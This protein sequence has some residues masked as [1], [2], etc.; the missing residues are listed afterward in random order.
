MNRPIAKGWCPGAYRPMM[1]G[2]GLVVR[3][4][5]VMV[6]LDR[7]QILGLC[8]LAERFGSGLIDLTSR[9]NL[10]IRGVEKTDHEAL[11]QELAGLGLLQD[12]PELEG[13]RN[14]LM[15]PLWLQGDASQQIVA[16]L[17][18]R[19]A[20]LP[21]LPVKMGFAVDTGPAPMLQEN[22]ADFRFERDAT[23][24]LILRADGAALGR[25]VEL[26]TALQAVLDMAD[27]FIETGGVASRRMASH[28]EKVPLPV[29][30]TTTAPAEKA[31]AMRPGT[32]ANA[33]VF[34]AAFGQIEAKAMRQLLQDSAAVALR[35]TPWRLF[36]L[37]GA[38]PVTSDTFI[39]QASDPLLQIN[40]CP[41]AP[42][43]TAASVD[44]RNTARDLAQR[45]DGPLHVSGCAK[46][47]AS[48][49]KCHTT[50]VGRGGAFDLV[51]DGLPWDEPQLSGLAPDTLTDR[52]GAR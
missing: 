52:I 9:A 10:Q 47:C 37:E 14:I 32:I 26:Q 45:I 5:P 18:Q 3:V 28:L 13:R 8:D 38:K 25:K 12:V 44:T 4:R 39:T 17:M 20:E 33:Q 23:G 2:D 6:R 7:A 43:C 36:I 46:G 22:S 24:G 35:V 15:T 34:G 50:L 1:S 48:P 21:D 31:E 27:W 51:R 49:R 11:L 42:F 30:W 41:G 29:Q 16:D 40:A 19:L